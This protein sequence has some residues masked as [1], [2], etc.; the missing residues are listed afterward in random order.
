[1]G[2]AVVASQTPAYAENHPRGLNITYLDDRAAA[3]RLF[4]NWLG[5]PDA[6]YIK[7]NGF[8]DTDAPY[9]QFGLIKAEGRFKPAPDLKLEP[10]TF[11]VNAVEQG[12]L[13]I[14][15]RGTLRG[16]RGGLQ[17]GL[18]VAPDSG[19]RQIKV[20]SQLVADEKRMRGKDP[21]IVRISGVGDAGAE[22]EFTIAPGKSPELTLI[23]RSPLPDAPEINALRA[24]RP[25]DAAPVHAGDS[26]VVIVKRKIL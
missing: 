11:T 19:V 12:E 10:P 25:K 23:E 16:A 7:A 6:G 9:L 2:V 15:V 20:A 14:V 8:P 21:V 24:A 13:N 22:F 1:M 4:V 17:L 26:A 5:A 3:P 18:G